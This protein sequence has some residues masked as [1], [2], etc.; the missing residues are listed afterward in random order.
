MVQTSGSDANRSSPTSESLLSSILFSYSALAPVKDLPFPSNVPFNVAHELFLNKLLLNHHLKQYPPSESYQ[1]SFWKWALERLEGL[2]RNDEDDEIDER[3]YAHYLFLITSARSGA[4]PNSFITHYWKLVE[5]HPHSMEGFYETITLLESRTTIEGGTTGLR[6]WRASLVLA[7]YLIQHPYFVRSSNVLELGSGTGFIGILVASLQL[8]AAN[9]P[10]GRKMPFIYLTD[11]N[12][13]VLGRCQN[14]VKLPCNKSSSHPNVHYASLDWLDSFSGQEGLKSFFNE[15]KVDI[16]LGADTVFDP[17]LVPPL[18]QTIFLAL[19]Y[20]PTQM[21]LIALTVRNKE[22]LRYFLDEIGKVLRTEEVSQDTTENPLLQIPD[23][24]D[25]GLEV[26]I[27]KVTR[28]S[29]A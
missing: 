20:K 21:A 15:A 2:P 23:Q 27:F 17:V 19:S 13:T 5:T 26:K 7:R 6:T 9:L 29:D 16:V 14:N 18:V 11:V 8:H 3:I 22:T 1:Q 12:S 10:F 25:A 4:P 28:E 24:I